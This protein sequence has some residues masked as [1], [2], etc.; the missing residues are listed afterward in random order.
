VA[1]FAGP[2]SRTL[3]LIVRPYED[4]ALAIA[5]DRTGPLAAERAQREFTGNVSHELRTPLTTM[6]LMLETLLLDP[7]D[8]EARA[9]FL[10]QIGG[11]VERMTRLVDDLLEL[12]RSE[13]GVIVLR[14]ARF[15][16]DELA[17][18]TLATFSARAAA[19]G[20]TLTRIAA[21]PVEVDGDRERLTQVIVNLLDNALRHTPRGGEVTVEAMREGA[22]AVLRVSDTGSGIPFAD[23]TRIFERFYVVD[24]SRSREHGGTGLGLAIARQ[25]VEAHRGRIGAESVYGRSTVFTV[26]IPDGAEP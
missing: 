25:V 22:A 6:R 3:R 17:A 2:R 12:S 19:G 5:I 4:G 14:R 15:R 18:A 9:L 23:L 21:D 24:R 11:E 7:E 16:L 26:R 20:I 1:L 10:P 8:A 13:S